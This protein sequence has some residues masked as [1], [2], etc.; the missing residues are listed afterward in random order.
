MQPSIG[1]RPRA[2]SRSSSASAA[3]AS[4]SASYEAA[5]VSASNTGGERAWQR[6]PTAARAFATFVYIRVDNVYPDIRL[7]D[8]RG[9]G[10][11]DSL[12][13]RWGKGC[14][15]VRI[16]GLISGRRG[17]RLRSI[18]P[19]EDLLR[20]CERLDALLDASF[21]G[22]IAAPAYGGTRSPPPRWQCV[23]HAS[24]AP[25]RTPTFWVSENRLNI[26]IVAGYLVTV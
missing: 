11:E 4:I 21:T 8:E 25:S 3:N 12:L 14:S 24:S 23:P 7:S 1:A 18:S 26:W 13:P 19:R 9:I 17:P 10:K 15:V 22:R 5:T 20:L 6:A 16:A 2:T